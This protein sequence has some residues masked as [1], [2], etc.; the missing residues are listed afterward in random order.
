VYQL[1]WLLK[2]K[3]PADA[4]VAEMFYLKGSSQLSCLLS[5]KLT[6]VYKAICL[7]QRKHLAKLC[8]MRYVYY[9]E[10][11]ELVA[12]VPRAQKIEG[13]VRLDYSPHPLSWPCCLRFAPVLKG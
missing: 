9:W 13:Q 6:T 2:G 1:N 10:A 3:Q 8:V 4:E 5:D 12:L 11:F 7:H